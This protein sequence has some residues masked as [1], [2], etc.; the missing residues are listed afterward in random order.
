MTDAVT[1]VVAEDEAIIRMDLV[2]VLR[3][4]GYA[5]VADTGRGDDAVRLVAE[6]RPD[7][8]LLDIKMPGLS[9]IEAAR[10]IAEQTDTAVVMLTAFSQRELIHDASDAGAMAYLVK[11][12][13]REDLV[14]ALELAIARRRETAALRNELSAAEQR[15]EERKLIDRAKG[16][17]IDHHTQSE[18]DA[19]QFLQRSAMSSRRR[20]VD[21]ATDVLEGRL[22]P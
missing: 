11:P 3:E 7:L 16:L 22:T 14:P 17:L 18:A 19:F 4:E 20:M 9:G 12:Y 6:H 1:V 8:A 21:V 2:E 15:I 13:Q 5:V 10:S